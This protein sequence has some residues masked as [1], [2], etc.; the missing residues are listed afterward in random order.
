MAFFRH[1]AT[2][3][4]AVE[5]FVTGITDLDIA[6]IGG[7]PRLYAMTRV[8]GGLSVFDLAPA[9]AAT[10]LETQAYATGPRVLAAPRIEILSAGAGDFLLPVGML[11]GTPGGISLTD[12]GR[13][14]TSVVFGTNQLAEPDLT[15]L[16]S[17]VIQGHAYVYAAQRGSDR[18]I[19][20][21]LTDSGTMQWVAG[22]AGARAGDSG[23]AP[24]NLITLQAAGRSFLISASSLDDRLVAYQLLADGTMTRTDGL[25][26]VSGVGFSHPG[27]IAGVT[28]HGASYVILAGMGSSSLSVALLTGAGRLVPVDHVIDGLETRFQ[29]VTALTT[30]SIGNRVF[31]LAAGADDGIS[32][33]TLLPDGRL[34]HLASIADSLATAL[35]NV[36]ALA[37]TVVGDRVQLFA[38]SEGEAGL[39]QFDLDLGRLG[40][41]RPS[42]AAL[43]SGT[44]D[45]DL[46]LA[47]GTGAT[48]LTGGAGDDILV[49]GAGAARMSGGAG[50]DIFVMAA[51]QHN[52]LV[53]DY[54]PG[55][56]RLDLTL[57]PML[58]S[59]SQLQIHSTAHGA[60][61][62]FG[63]TVIA[64]ISATGTPIPVSD[65]TDA[66]VL[67]LSRY[68][69]APPPIIGT[70]VADL[71]TGGAASNR[72]RGLA[73]DDTLRGGGGN[74]TL[75]SGAGNDRVSAGPGDDRLLGGDGNDTLSGGIGGDRGIGGLGA[76]TILGGNGNDTLNGGAGNDWIRGGAGADTFYFAPGGGH[77]RID[78][79]SPQQGDRLRFNADLWQ[80]HLTA[81]QVV[82]G[83]A[84]L[85][86]GGVVVDFDTGG[87]VLLAGI[88]MLD[89]LAALIDIF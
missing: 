33:F 80:G 6:W 60:R 51:N 18:L 69:P 10:V 16:A 37:A 77:D 52:N 86:A 78:D 74:D 34:I 13:F 1:V 7:Q 24:E 15:A 8:G 2:I 5:R 54:A 48:S 89:Q 79:F 82:A 20:Y 12:D 47:T 58:H 71:L 72:I 63:D 23:I 46:L 73:G 31:V 53:L 28:L 26:S 55:V 61:L 41:S 19:S 85:A 62:Q 36:T 30:L 84:S 14:G 68:E 38:A 83:H 76:D 29:T 22:T 56:D 39:T 43:I 59:I 87:Q 66:V 35:S 27:A 49:A 11:Q 81:A 9:G 64:L 21:A 45:N 57:I 42:A 17:Q 67:S 44:A 4:A 65:F 3:V 70:G 32:L 40:V 50:S 25:D 75:N 88:A